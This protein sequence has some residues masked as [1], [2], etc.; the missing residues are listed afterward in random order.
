M[1][2]LLHCKVEI[3]LSLTVQTT[4]DISSSCFCHEKIE[5]ICLCLFQELYKKNLPSTKLKESV[6]LTV[7]ALLNTFQQDRRNWE[8]K[9]EAKI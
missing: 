7:G 8:S 5:D 4:S 9:V 2:V 6:L 1:G 3:K